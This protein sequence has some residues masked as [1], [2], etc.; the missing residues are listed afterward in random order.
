MEETEAAIDCLID[1]NG[2]YIERF[3]T[4]VICDCMASRGNA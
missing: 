4:F 2:L 1:A 3:R